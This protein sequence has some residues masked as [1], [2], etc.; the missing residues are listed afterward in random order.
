[1]V[2]VAL[3]LMVVVAVPIVVSIGIIPIG[4][5]GLLVDFHLEFA[6]HEGQQVRQFLLC[7][8]DMQRYTIYGAIPIDR[9]HVTS[10]AFRSPYW[11]STFGAKF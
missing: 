4:R 7:P 6:P 2:A 8:R 9:F 11:W 1:M 10:H 3:S 5:I